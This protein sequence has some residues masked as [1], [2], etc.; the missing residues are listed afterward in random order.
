M[1]L[2]C[3]DDDLRNRLIKDGHR[4]IYQGNNEKGEFWCFEMQGIFEFSEKDKE[5]NNYTLSKRMSF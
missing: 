3:F 4:L 1:F 5:G 2:Y